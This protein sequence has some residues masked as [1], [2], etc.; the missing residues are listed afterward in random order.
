[1]EKPDKFGFSCFNFPVKELINQSG[2]KP[3]GSQ[4][5]EEWFFILSILQ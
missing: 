1:M 2:Q 4:M 5:T 3:F